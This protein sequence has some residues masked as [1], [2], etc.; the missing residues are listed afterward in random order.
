MAV[1]YFSYGAIALTI[2]VMLFYYLLQMIKNIWFWIIFIGCLIFPPAAPFVMIFMIFL[3][4]RFLFNHRRAIFYGVILYAV[5]VLINYS[6]TNMDHENFLNSESYAHF[7]SFSLFAYLGVFLCS[8]VMMHLMLY[9]LYKKGYVLKNAIILMLEFPVLFI[10]LV[11]AV[12]GVFDGHLFDKPVND[13]HFSSSDHSGFDYSH[14]HSG[15]FHSYGDPGVHEVQSY[16]RHGSN[17]E[18]Q[19]VRAYIRTNPDGIP[20]NNFSYRG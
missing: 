6:C 11:I 8:A 17:G 18:L 20:E 14:S 9:S 4:M 19:F 1:E 15:D 13:N 7:S 3:R 10:L 16:V 5:P 12:A 2:A